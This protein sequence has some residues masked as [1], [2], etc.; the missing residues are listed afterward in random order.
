ML[1]S[2]PNPP[3]VVETFL[4]LL[5]LIDGVAKA[6]GGGGEQYGG[7][8]RVTGINFASLFLLL[9]VSPSIVQVVSRVDDGS[10][11]TKFSFIAGE[12]NL[13]S[14]H[15]AIWME[16]RCESSTPTNSNFTIIFLLLFFFL[17]PTFYETIHIMTEKG[18]E[19]KT[20]LPPPLSCP[21]M[22]EGEEEVWAKKSVAQSFPFSFFLF[23][24]QPKSR[25]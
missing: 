12:A 15:S 6:T 1:P 18:Y 10:Y 7:G 19:K 4:L 3:T 11:V 2:L 20:F 24:M 17:A 23:P 13:N 9:S 5:L 8:G 22:E 25:R 16:M 21:S 14:D